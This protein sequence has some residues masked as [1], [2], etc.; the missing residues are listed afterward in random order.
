[1]A[2]GVYSKT[3]KTIAG[4][5]TAVVAGW[6]LY[7]RHKYIKTA[8][9]EKEVLLDMQVVPDIDGIGRVGKTEEFLIRFAFEDYDEIGFAIKSDSAK[10]AVKKAKELLFEMYGIN[11]EDDFAENNCLGL[12]TQYVDDSV[13]TEKYYKTAK[14]IR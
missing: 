5:I 3:E 9:K 14:K 8:Q 12:S 13:R 10:N 4:I 1:M 2:N 6:V 11:Y 7:Q